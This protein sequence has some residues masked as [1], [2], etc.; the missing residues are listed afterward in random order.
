ML[1]RKI[2]KATKWQMT[3]IKIRIGIVKN[4]L[5]SEK[6]AK[7]STIFRKKLGID[8]KLAKQYLGKN[9]K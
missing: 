4:R 3:C 1:D 5:I 6:Y 8:L 2:N 9:I 7:I